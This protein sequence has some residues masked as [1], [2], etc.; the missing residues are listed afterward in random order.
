MA[1]TFRIEGLKE[2]E[3]ALLEISHAAGA[4]VLEKVGTA[5][6]QAIAADASERAPDG[7]FGD[8]KKDIIVTPVRPKGEPK[9]STVEIFAGPKPGRKA[10][11][12]E[13][14]TAPHTIFA[15]ASNVNGVMTF[16]IDGRFVSTAVVH[17]PGAAP[18]PFLRPA[19]D[20]GAM[21]LLDGIGKDLFAEISAVAAKNNT[22]ASKG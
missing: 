17:H 11:L 9:L 18:S 20:S 6:L 15:K 13:F 14:G 4:L 10:H 8:L 3:R 22:R 1:E 19:W 16:T 7:V 21:A 12:V 5:R 2:V